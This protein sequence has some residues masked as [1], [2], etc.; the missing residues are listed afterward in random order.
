VIK[1]RKIIWAGHAAS[2]GG[3]KLIK[4]LGK[5]LNYLSVDERIILKWMLNKDG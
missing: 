4:S 1:L 3:E 5:H 2:L